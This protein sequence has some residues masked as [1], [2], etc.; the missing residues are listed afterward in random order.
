MRYF[1]VYLLFASL[2]YG[3]LT[4]ITAEYEDNWLRIFIKGKF[5][6]RIEKT[7]SPEGL[8]ISIL[9][10]PTPYPNGEEYDFEDLK[11]KIQGSKPTEIVITTDRILSYDD[12]WAGDNLVIV[13]KLRKVRKPPPRP[14]PTEIP[15]EKQA[16][17]PTERYFV[18]LKEVK[19]ETVLKALSILKGEEIEF[20]IPNRV[21]LSLDNVSLDKIIENLTTTE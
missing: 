10:E 20:N 21:T 12:Y 4:D 6:Y 19:G 2:V 8:R 14:K 16:V 18:K 1:T 13:A 7:T 9:N 17:M 5:Q 11:V 15:Q 3:S